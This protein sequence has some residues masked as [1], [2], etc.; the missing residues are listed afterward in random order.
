ML[1]VEWLGKS[2]GSSYEE[3]KK[4]KRMLAP[5]CF[6]LLRL[7]YEVAPPRLVTIPQWSSSFGICPVRMV[8]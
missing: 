5:Y 4:E 2:V 1:R 6:F 7:C 8:K 3:R